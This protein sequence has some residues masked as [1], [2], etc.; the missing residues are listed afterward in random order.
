MHAHIWKTKSPC[1][2][3]LYIPASELSFQVQQQI[4]PPQIEIKQLTDEQI[5][6]LD[7]DKFAKA[8]VST[9]T[10]AKINDEKNKTGKKKPS[11]AD[12][13]QPTDVKET[14]D[15]LED[16]KQ[17]DK[18]SQLIERSID[19]YNSTRN[20]PQLIKFKDTAGIPGI[21]PDQLNPDN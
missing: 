11:S 4:A 14:L 5:A 17:N 19:E 20:I 9:E 10:L 7:K 3:T 12:I 1:T 21:K 2:N 16:E 18:M 15:K 8:S 6:K 13:S